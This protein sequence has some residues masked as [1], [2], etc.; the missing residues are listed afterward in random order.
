MISII[1]QQTDDDSGWSRKKEDREPLLNKVNLAICKN[2]QNSKF[3]KLST[4]KD[5][6]G[7]GPLEHL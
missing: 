2:F 1:P 3:A 7:K 6:G 5:H 4:L